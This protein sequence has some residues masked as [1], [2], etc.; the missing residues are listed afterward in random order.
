MDEGIM[1]EVIGVKYCG[2]CR[3]FLQMTEFVDCLKKNVPEASFVPWDGGGMFSRLLLLCA[4]PAVCV[5]TSSF[6][7][8]T[9]VISCNTLDFIEYAAVDELLDA[10]AALINAA[11]RAES[12]QKN[13]R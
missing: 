7:G 3:P 2:H 9:T 8:P 6:T 10:A 11:A 5:R 13:I 1:G 4:C 12:P